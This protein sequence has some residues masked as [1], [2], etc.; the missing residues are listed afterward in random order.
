[1]SY[2]KIGWNDYDDNLTFEENVDNNAVATD[3]LLNHM[4][5]GIAKANNIQIGNVSYSGEPFVEMVEKPD[6]YL[7]N[8]GF[9]KGEKGEKG[10]VG[11]AGSDG[12]DGKNATIT[13]Q[14]T[15]TGEPGTNAVVFNTGTESDAVLNFVIPRGDKGDP[16]KD[17][18]NG[19]D[20]RDGYAATVNIGEVTTLEAGE[21]AT[22]TNV[23]TENA[24]ILNFGIPRGEN[25]KD[26]GTSIGTSATIK[27]GEVATGE[28]GTEASVTNSGTETN[29]IL[30]FVI[31]K[32]DKGD[33]GEKGDPGEQGPAGVDGKAATISIGEVTTLEAGEQATVT[34]IGTENAAI[35]NFYIPKGEKGESVSSELDVEHLKNILSLGINKNDG[36]LYI[37]IDGDPIGNGVKIGNIE[38]PV[39]GDPVA[40]TISLKAS[41]NQTIKIGIKLSRKPTQ[42]QTITLLSDSQLISFN[43]DRLYFTTAD[44]DEIQYVDITIGYVESDSTYNIIM[45]NSDELQTDI[46]IPISLL[47]DV[48]DVDTTIPEGAHILTEDDV[49]GILAYEQYG[50]IL[51]TYTGSYT[52]VIIPSSIEYNGVSYS[53]VAVSP[54]TFSNSNVVQYITIEDGALLS[55]SSTNIT[56]SLNSANRNFENCTSLIGIKIP[57]WNRINNLNGLFKGCTSLKFVDGLENLK[58]ISSMNEIFMNCTSLE[59]IQDLSGITTTRFEKN[60]YTDGNN[61]CNG[62]TSLKKVYGIPDLT[63][64]S[65]AFYNCINLEET[66][67]PATVGTY[68]IEYNGGYTNSSYASFVVNGCVNLKKLTILTEVANVSIPSNLNNECIIYAIEGSPVY[69]NLQA[70]INNNPNAKLLPY[71]SSEVDA[72]SIVVW[73][74]STSSINTNWIDWPTRLSNKL[75]TYTIK[76]QAV[77][78]EYTTSTSARQGGNK[79]Y[80]SKFTIPNDKTPISISLKTEDGHVFGSNPVFSAGG[81]FNPCVIN[82][83]R[84]VITNNSGLYT[85]TRSDNGSQV[86]INDNTVISSASDVVLNSSDVMLINLGINSGWDEDPDIL[87]NQVQLMVNHYIEL[88]GEKY[89]VSGPWSGKHLRTEELRSIV[90]EYEEKAQEAFGEHWLNIRQY[91]IDYGLSDNELVATNVDNERISIG[92]VPGS[93]LGGGDTLNILKYPDTSNDDTHPN[94]YGAI[95]QCNAFYKKGVELGYWD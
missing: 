70:S 11:P 78:G 9:P 29:A 65:N 80:T 27:I 71:G 38:E 60:N 68:E 41:S 84:G 14:D 89:I 30:N 59:Y 50:A 92:Q 85:F 95:A 93:L 28:P 21:Q 67:I 74:D 76:N 26:G 47:S 34:N 87:L 90:F 15:M 2:E 18:A 6:R 37:F 61:M 54:I 91:M 86:E 94:M 75:S 24:A 7:M 62:C 45:R 46:S 31:P 82:E 72:K 44:W 39:Y 4:D 69:T 32:G 73:G 49:D 58:L 40:D 13:V 66:I 35:L 10:D 56:T 64:M 48:Y 3:A 33:Q 88:G 77:S 22:V 17:G 19:I 42:E 63:N 5:D 20:G 23:G 57:A 83:V 52:N 43:P 25:G 53:P 81:S 36:L 55:S 1:M 79:L 12:S 16:G 8:F 51:K